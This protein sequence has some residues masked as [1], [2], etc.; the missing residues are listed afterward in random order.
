MHRQ[1]DYKLVVFGI[2]RLVPSASFDFIFKLARS[3][4]SINDFRTGLE[5]F[6]FR[7]HSGFQRRADESENEKLE[8]SDG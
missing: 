3:R 2:K 7:S 6:S 1:F 5:L 8:N 4:C